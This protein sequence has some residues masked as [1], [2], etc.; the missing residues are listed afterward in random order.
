[1][2]I[3]KPC[4]GLSLLGVLAASAMAALPGGYTEQD[5]SAA[6]FAEIVETAERLVNEKAPERGFRCEKL[7]EVHTQVVAGINYR[8]VCHYRGRDGAGGMELLL[9]RGL[10]GKYALTRQ[11][12]VPQGFDYVTT[13]GALIGVELLPGDKLAVSYGKTRHVLPRAVSGSG[14]KYSADGVTFWMK[15]GEAI[16]ELAKSGEKVNCRVR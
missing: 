8:L 13:F 3:W 2:R 11:T 10:D 7:V 14:A 6:E 4:V 15:G 5:P 1:M 12:P 9:F 16:L